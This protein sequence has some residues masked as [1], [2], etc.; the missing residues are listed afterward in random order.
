[1]LQIGVLLRME[2]RRVQVYSRPVTLK[3]DT[4]DLGYVRFSTDG[5]E[6]GF[7]E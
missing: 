3:P 2:D 4:L 5:S 1:M 7:I 6:L